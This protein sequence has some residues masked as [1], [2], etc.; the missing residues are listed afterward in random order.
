VSQA[1][2]TE[3]RELKDKFDS[4]D[5]CRTGTVSEIEATML[6]TNIGI[7]TSKQTER[8]A[9]TKFYAE[10]GHHRVCFSMFLEL[11]QT[12]RNVSM[13]AREAELRKLF[14]ATD[15]DRSGFLSLAECS[16]LLSQMG[17]SP[18]TRAQQRRIAALFDVADL[19]GSGDL[20]F[21]EFAKLFQ[22]VHELLESAFRKEVLS[23]ADS[24]NISHQQVEEYRAAFDIF[25]TADDGMLRIEDIRRL[26][27]SVHV[28]ISGD[29]LNGIIAEVDT[30]HSGVIEFDEFLK[31]ISLIEERKALQISKGQ[32]M[33]PALLASAPNKAEPTE[34]EQMW[35]SE[36][37]NITRRQKKDEK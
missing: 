25:D 2:Q 37:G 5:L 34:L 9:I 7:R 29:L 17:M 1:F 28:T 35:M 21:A 11:L 24:L 23:M 16:R 26:V 10:R 8:D 6:L 19:D 20:D 36:T 31:L 33:V 3:I 4:A 12:A 13:K 18:K 22:H 27:D 14:M 30:D 15:D 32:A